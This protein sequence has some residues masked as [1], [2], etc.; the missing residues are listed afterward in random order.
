MNN[1]LSAT[2]WLSELKLTEL[3]GLLTLLSML[4]GWAFQ[5][6]IFLRTDERQQATLDH[7]QDFLSEE[8]VHYQKIR[9]PK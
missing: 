5:I 4:A 1:I 6:H 2:S 3:L 9:F 8:F 7:L